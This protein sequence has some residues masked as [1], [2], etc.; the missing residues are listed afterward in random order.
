MTETTPT[1][2]VDQALTA[3]DQALLIGTAMP[4]DTEQDEEQDEE[5]VRLWGRERNANDDDDDDDDDGGGG[6]FTYM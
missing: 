3:D 2:T 4:E 6:G 1:T 5:Q